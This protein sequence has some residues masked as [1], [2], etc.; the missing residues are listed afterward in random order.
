M[1][2]D[3]SFLQAALKC[4]LVSVFLGKSWQC[5]FYQVDIDSADELAEKYNVDV[6]PTIIVFK[7]GKEV[8]RI[9]GYHEMEEFEEFL[10]QAIKA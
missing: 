1:I 6:V 2:K 9:T 8:A 3:Y 10:K 7:S 4:Q 5:F